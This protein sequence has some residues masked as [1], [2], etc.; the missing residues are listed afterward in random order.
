MNEK[1]WYLKRCDLF[2]RLSPKELERVESRCRA[3]SFPR[4]TPIYLP[5]DQSQAV[6]LLASGRVKICHATPDGKQ[7]I[8]AF[9]EPGEL[10]GELAVF[11]SG[12][13]DEYAETLDP[14]TVVMIPREEVQRLM[15]EHPVVSM[16]LTRM[17]GLRRRRI[18]RRL[19]NLLFLSN[20]DRLTHL[21][22][23]LA[24]QYGEPGAEGVRLRIRLSHQDLAS[25]IGSTRETVTGVL[26]ELQGEGLVRVGRKKILIRRP[27]RLAEQVERSFSP[28]PRPMSRAAAASSGS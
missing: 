26:G 20:R 17:M 22:L 28:P 19:K 18:E 3:K 16:S 25:I 2:E 24:E 8:L 12:A 9:V 21:L 7:A 4:N 11:D 1:L 5:I 27:E 15:E 13:R 10:F 14:S 23:E 6:F